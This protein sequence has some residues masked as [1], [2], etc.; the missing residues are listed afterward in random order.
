[1]KKYIVV[2]LL[3]FGLNVKTYPQQNN[4]FYEQADSLNVGYGIAFSKAKSAFSSQSIQVERLGNV[5]HIDVGKALYGRIAGLNVY[6]GAGPSSENLAVLSFH[7]QAPLVLVDGFPRDIADIVISEIESISVLKDA[8]SAA[9]YG[10]RGAN[11]IVMI[12]TKRGQ[13]QRLKVTADYTLGF[14]T[15]FRSPVFAD[16]Y[17]YAL[18]LNSA[19]LSDGL[20]RRYDENELNAFKNNTF[21]YEYPNVN[22]WKECYNNLAYNHRLKLTFNGGN[23]RFRYFSA[24]DYMYDEGFFKENTSDRR[25][26]SKPTDI[27]LNLRTNM[28]VNVTPTTYLKLGVMGKLM[29]TNRARY[30]N[31]YD[32]IYNTP[33]AAFP[34][35]YENGIFG[36]N[37]IYTANNP[38][39]LLTATGAYKTT[40][41]IL[42]ADAFL[43]QRLDALLPGL[44]AAIAVTFDNLGA[45]YDTSSKQYRYMDAQPSILDDGITLVTNPIIYGR[46][47]EVLSHGHG[48]TSLS[49]RSSF[50]G[51]LNYQRTF[52]NINDVSAAFIYD[53]QSYIHNGR[54]ESAKRQS[55]I[56]IASYTYHK[57]YSINAVLNYS[58][59][60][61]LARENRHQCYPAISTAWVVS[62]EKFMQTQQLLDFFKLHASYGISG[63]DGNLTHE[64]YRQGYGSEY[65]NGYFFTNNASYFGGQGEGPLPIENLAPEKST[66]FTYGLDVAFLNNRLMFSLE[67]FHEKR[68][69]IL[70][71]A[72]AV[73]GIIGINVLQQ[74][75]GIQEYY[76]FDT[77]IR[78]KQSINKFNYQLYANGA[79]LDSKIINDNQE[80]QEYDYLYRKGNRVGQFYGLEVKGFFHDQMQINNSP[81]QTFSIVRPGDIMYKDQNGDGIINE[82]D[83]VRMFGSS[84]PRFYFGFGVDA[85]YGNIKFSVDFQGLTGRTVNLLSSKLYQPLVENGNISATF[86]NNEI[87]WSPENASSA[88]MPR[89]TT[90]PNANNYRNNSLWF[91]D[92]SFIKLRNIMLAYTFPKKMTT[93]ADIEIYIQGTDLFSADNIKT[94]DPEQLSSGYPTSMS[95]W[96]GIKLNF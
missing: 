44:S 90:L 79:Y 11:G 81:V 35:K 21:P 57:R 96:A 38:V 25:F 63:W 64:L 50:Q 54:N 37:S 62:E 87:P 31:I 16:A 48:F 39:A 74:N 93:F 80:Y 12:T 47:S 72:N 24:I 36:G 82:K 76:G 6:Q 77:A 85:S 18:S 30:Q 45:M 5:P 20:D 1:M 53:Q 19:L 33:A 67:G 51:K 83:V 69:N 7:G 23:D 4:G 17:T 29:E 22:W 92:G 65:G 14:H 68:S 56:G 89:L 49:M 60:A 61:Y 59:T 10:V 26:S 75:A 3:I 15:Q 78:W 27:R 91:R 73:S 71:P 70:V 42:L 88:T 58:G 34:V 32:A 13:K 95:Y 9:L 43:T 86:L 40:Y 28:D 55:F 46:D 8:T 41:G 66:M 2:I 84:V 52:N 94:L